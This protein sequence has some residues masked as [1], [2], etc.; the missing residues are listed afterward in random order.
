[1]T[2]ELE[3]RVQANLPG[4]LL[5]WTKDQGLSRQ[6]PLVLSRK[7]GVDDRLKVIRRIQA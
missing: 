7:R 6:S 3:K 4:A 1:M 5:A 2:I